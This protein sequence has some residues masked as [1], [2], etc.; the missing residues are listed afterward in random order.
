MLTDQLL[1]HNEV[2]TSLAFGAGG[3]IASGSFEGEVIWWSEDPLFVFGNQVPSEGQQHETDVDQVAFLDDDIVVSLDTAGNLLVASITDGVG[4]FVEGVEPGTVTGIAATDDT[5]AVGFVDGTVSLSIGDNERPLQTTHTDPVELVEL[6]AD[7]QRL[8][9][10]SRSP[11]SETVGSIAVWNAATG[12]LLSNPVLPDDFEVFSA[13]HPGGD[14]VWLGGR[15]TQGPVALRFDTTSGQ[16][17]GPPLRH[18]TA[19]QVGALAEER[20][21]SM[22][23]TS[24]GK[25]LVTGGSDRKI[26]AWKLDTMERAAG[27]FIGHNEEVTGLVF[28][29]NDERLVS[30]DLDLFVNYWDVSERRLITSFGGPSDGISDMALSPDGLTL[31]VASE[32]DFVYTWTLDP[33]EWIE[34]ACL[35]AGRNMT[36]VEWSLYGRGS[37]V[38]HCDFPGEGDLA[39]YSRILST[40]RPTV[41]PALAPTTAAAGTTAPTPTS[42]TAPPGTTMPPVASTVAETVAADAGVLGDPVTFELDPV[43]FEL[44]NQ[45]FDGADFDVPDGTTQLT[46]SI[47]ETSS[48]DVDLF[49][50]EPGVYVP[51]TEPAEALAICASNG[52]GSDESCTIDGV[53][54]GTWT[55]VVLNHTASGSAPD[56]IDVVLAVTVE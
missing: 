29:E 30:A 32:D 9:T 37:Y 11:D 4:E 24:N 36:Q 47:G 54:P 41:E 7:A 53:E 50:Y 48:P 46:V 28:I 55:V 18:G 2:I 45:M 35:L 43:T 5:L 42:A 20:V 49:V 38:R 23:A 34:R 31:A 8:V 40:K 21:V 13:L 39:D 15:D 44:D 22:A 51:G 10:G 26:H 3:E 33:D 1:G 12:D 25:L 19:E 14:V 6:S 52:D 56:V 17:M 16:L 27:S